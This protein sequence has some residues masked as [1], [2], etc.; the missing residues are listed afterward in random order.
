MVNARPTPRVHATAQLLCEKRVRGDVQGLPAD[1]ATTTLDRVADVSFPDV[2]ILVNNLGTFEPKRLDKS[3]T[4][5][6]SVSAVK[7]MKRCP[8]FS[9]RYPPSIRKLIEHPGDVGFK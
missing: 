6:G 4:T 8:I 2:N 7:V 5:S 1:L 3:P 9:R